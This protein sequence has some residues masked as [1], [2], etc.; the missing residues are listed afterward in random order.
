MAVDPDIPPEQQEMIFLS[1]GFQEGMNWRLNGELLPGTGRSV[2]WGLKEGRHTLSLLDK[3]GKILDKV[4]FL[5]R[6]STTWEELPPNQWEIS[7]FSP[8]P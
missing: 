4:S 7:Q 6:G 5:V 2:R 3:D 8:S 1:E